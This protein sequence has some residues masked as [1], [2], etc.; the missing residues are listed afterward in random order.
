MEYDPY[1][2]S[3]IDGEFQIIWLNLLGD[4]QL[5]ILN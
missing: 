4:Y 1:Y 5:L 2:F 3:S